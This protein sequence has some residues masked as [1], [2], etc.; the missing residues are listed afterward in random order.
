MASAR[1]EASMSEPEASRG[2][3][4]GWRTQ[5]LL[6]DLYKVIE[7]RKDCERIGH[8]PPTYFEDAS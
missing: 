8:Q 3:I 2:G 1:H 4:R 6:A 7:G 5:L